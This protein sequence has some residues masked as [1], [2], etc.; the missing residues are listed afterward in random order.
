[1][2]DR[3]DYLHRQ[4]ETMAPHRAVLRA[5]EC[6]LMGQLDLS[7]PVLDIG[8]GDG[9]FTSIAYEHP[10]DVG[11]DL[12]PDEVAEARARGT[13]VYRFVL[14]A[15]A[16]SMPFPAGSFATVVS[17]CVIEHIPDVDAVLGDISRVL[18]PGG[19][20]AT[21]LPS[22]FFGEYLLGA[23]V[24]RRIGLKRLATAY[25]DWFNNISHH[26]H[27]DPPDVW[28]NRLEAAGLDVVEHEYYF[29]PGAH[30]AFDLCHYLSVPHLVTRKLLGRWVIHPAINRP[31]ER[32]LR[33]Y[34]DEPLPQPTGAYQ[35]IHCVRRS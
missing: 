32:W 35:F 17:N 6:R 9:H 33:R 30:R 16:T 26:H 13:T 1:M 24:L 29:S 27:V 18:Q 34:V 14:Q 2:T 7:A 31:F 28:K 25:G 20:F 22:E 5:V 10:L 8:C 19:T 15:D 21:T 12:R 3:P 4:L 23:T 11:I